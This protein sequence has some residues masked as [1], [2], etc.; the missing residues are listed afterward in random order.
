MKRAV[1]MLLTSLSFLGVSCERHSW[2][3]TKGLHHHGGGESKDHGAKN[4][5]EGEKKEQAPH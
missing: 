3:D 1:V 4:H 2:E 5:A